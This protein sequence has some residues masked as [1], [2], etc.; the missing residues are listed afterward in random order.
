MIQGMWFNLHVANLDESEAFYRE[1]GFEIKKNPDMLDKMLGIA[2]GDTTVILIENKHF[3]NVSQQHV[4]TMPN[5]VMISLGVKT[6]EEVDQLVA[7]V[8]QA[9][10]IVVQEPTVSQGYYGAMFKDLDGHHYNFLVC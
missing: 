1:L 3:E 4:D 2:I 10:G 7:K 6:N 5:E 8:K 9:G